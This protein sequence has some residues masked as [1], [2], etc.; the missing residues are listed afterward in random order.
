MLNVLY[1][2]S[3]SLWKDVVDAAFLVLGRIGFYLQ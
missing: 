3:V 1:R 2:S